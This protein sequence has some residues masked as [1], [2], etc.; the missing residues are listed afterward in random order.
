MSCGC[1]GANCEACKNGSSLYDNLKK[2]MDAALSV[3]DC[4]GAALHP[5]QILTRTWSGERPGDGTAVESLLDIYPTPQIVDYGHDIRGTQGG[6]IRQGDIILRGISKNKFPLESA[7]DCSTTSRK[8]EKFYFI[9]ERLYT[10]IHVKDK[11][12]TWD[13]HLRKRSD[14]TRNGA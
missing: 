14:E 5:V 9:A 13:V 2:C 3:R 6:F 4:V 10:V 8:I 1:G 11:P 7:I 12:V